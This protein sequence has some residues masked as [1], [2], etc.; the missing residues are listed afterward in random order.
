M[1]GTYLGKQE[2]TIL[3]TLLSE[4]SAVRKKHS[5]GLVV[6]SIFA[7][8][9]GPT[10]ADQQQHITVQKYVENQVVNATAYSNEVP[11]LCTVGFASN[12]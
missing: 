3:F 12:S 10:G 2:G 5:L 4:I 1:Q 9:L 11:L 8:W 7:S 6:V